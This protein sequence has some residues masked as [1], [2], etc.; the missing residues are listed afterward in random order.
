MWRDEKHARR[1]L[2]DFMAANGWFG[3]KYSMRDK[4][5]RIAAADISKIR[6]PLVL[7]LK[8][9]M[10]S[11]RIKTMLM[12]EQFDRKLPKTCLLY[13]KFLD[14]GGKWDDEGAWKL[15]DYLLCELESE[16]TD[17]SEDELERLV[18][19]ANTELP[20]STVR[21]FA[22]LLRFKSDGGAEL[23][24][25]RYSFEASDHPGLINDAYSLESFSIMAYC[26]F[27]EDVWSKRDLIKKA[28]ESPAYSD[29]WLFAALHFV[30]ALRKGDMA[31]LP[32]PEL[33]YDAGD[34][35]SRILGG[36]FAR[37]EAVALTNELMR[38]LELQP[39]LPSKTAARGHV[40]DLKLY[41]PASLREPIGMII[42]I[43]LGHHPEIQ[44][45]DGF[46]M[47]S[48]NM[49]HLRNFFGENLPLRSGTVG[50]HPGAATN[51][52]CRA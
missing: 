10:Q 13:R 16:I 32:A 49:Q 36:S 15:L 12:L 9:Y 39:Q 48:D 38:R 8:A 44:P 1:R 42:A 35:H 5:P 21:L 24:V 51:R 37:S 22:E 26:V 29:L 18:V 17:C 50:F 7:W 4:A 45:G 3:I 23:S 41:V 52:I 20:L 33:P 28:V 19:R 40:P 46:V 31:R 2:L 25:W 11:G 30:C 47:P 14:E 34:V 43:V 6:G 27:N